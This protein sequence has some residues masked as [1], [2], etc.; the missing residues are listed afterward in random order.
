L[1]LTITGRHFEVSKELKQYI[2]KRFEKWA[3]FLAPETEVHVVL[4]VENYRQIAEVNANDKRYSITGKQ[5]SKDMFSSIDLLADKVGRQLARQHE[6][7]ASKS[8]APTARKPGAA[9]RPERGIREKSVT[10]RIVDVK[11]PDGKPMT[12]E[13]AALEF[14]S[15]RQQFM[16]FEDVE[17]GQLAVMT[18]RKDG[19][20]A[21]II[22]D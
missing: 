11:A 22:K 18:R 20:F 15:S 9:S 10:G 16:V 14:R 17:T 4:T 21:L 13:E 6:K 12:R 19:N 2:R 7:L 5:T 8:G 1:E 3:T